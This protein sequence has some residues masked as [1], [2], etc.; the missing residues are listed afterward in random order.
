MNVEHSRILLMC[1]Q[2]LNYIMD[3][4]FL[5]CLQGCNLST[6]MSLFV[7]SSSLSFL[8]VH[9]E[10]LNDYYHCFAAVMQSEG[11]GYLE[12]SCPSLLSELLGVIASVDENLTMLSS[13]KRSGSSILGL[14]LPADG[15][16]PAESASGR[17]RRRRF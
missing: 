7:E 14:D 8:S 16:G 12:E 17:R 4:Q 15:G 13:K 2:C 3:H 9:V 5:Y 10:N 11:F 1:I 6:K